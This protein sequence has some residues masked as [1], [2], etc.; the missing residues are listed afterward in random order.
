Y[1]A[2]RLR[3]IRQKEAEEAK[4][5][6]AEAAS[7]EGTT[8]RKAS[9]VRVGTSP[10]QATRL[11]RAFDVFP[12][13]DSLVTFWTRLQVDLTRESVR[14]TCHLPHGLSRDVRVLAFC[15]DDQ[16][17]EMLAA[18]ADF[19][20]ITEPLRRINQG[21]LGF[22][23]CLATPSIMPRVLSV[24]KILGPRKLIPNP[25]SG[26]VVTNLQAAI[27]EA[28]GGTLLEYRAEGEGEVKA[29][30]ADTNFSDAKI[31]ENLKFLV[32]TLLRAR[33]R[34]STAGEQ[35]DAMR[36]PPGTPLIKGKGPN[37]SESKDLYFQEAYLRLGTRGPPI[38]MDPES[39]MPSSVGAPEP[40]G[41]K[42]GKK[43]ALDPEAAARQAAAENEE[44]K[45]MEMIREAKRLRENCEREENHFHQ[46][47]ME[48]E[49]INYFWIV[50]KKTLTE[51]QA[52]LR[53]KQRELQ[54]LEERQ[55]IE[56]KMFQQR[57]KHLRY[58]Q[59][60]EVVEL[61]TDAELSLK[62]QEDHHRITEAEIKK[63]QRA[64]KMEKKESEVAQ[65]DFTRMLKLEQDGFDRKARDMQQKYELR[66]KTIREEMEKQRRKQIQ[67]IEESKNAQIEQVMKK[68]NLDFT[69]IKVYYQEITVSNFDSI[70]RLKEDYA[71]IKKDEND[72][73]KKM[74]D[75]EQRSK[76]LKEP[77]KKANQ[78]VE[79]LERE[80][81]A[82][83]EDKKRLT[84]VK[85]Q[86][87]QSETLLKRMEFQ[88]EVLQQQLSQVTSEREDLYTK[89]QQAI[90]DVQQR[91]GLKNLILEKKI[92][93]VEEALETTEAQI[94]ELLASAN[95]RE[96]AATIKKRVSSSTRKIGV[97]PTTSA[98]ITQKLDQV[99]AYKDDIV[100]QLEDA[101]QGALEATLQS[102]V[103]VKT[104]ESKMAE[105]GVP[106]EDLFSRIGRD[107]IPHLAT[108]LCRI[109]DSRPNAKVPVAA[110]PWHLHRETGGDGRGALLPLMASKG[111]NGPTRPHVAVPRAVLLT[112]EDLENFHN[113]ALSRDAVF[114]VHAV[115]HMHTLTCM[116]LGTA[117]Y[118][119]CG[120]AFLLASMFLPEST[121]IEIFTDYW[122]QSS[123]LDRL[124]FIGKLRGIATNSR[125]RLLLWKA[126]GE[127]QFA[128]A[129]YARSQPHGTE[130]ISVKDSI[131]QFSLSLPSMSLHVAHSSILPLATRRWLAAKHDN[132]DLTASTGQA[133]PRPYPGREKV[134]YTEEPKARPHRSLQRCNRDN[135]PNR[136]LLL[137]FLRIII[138]IIVVIIIIST[139][140]I[141]IIILVV[142]VIMIIM[143]VISLHHSLPPSTVSCIAIVGSISFVVL[144]SLG[145]IVN[146]EPNVTVEVDGA[147]R[148]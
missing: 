21:W 75:L 1:R 103:S 33:P 18:G 97:D 81:V 140:A 62:L 136:V 111:R 133:R 128:G 50:E 24:A 145:F 95:A 8:V 91:S 76:Q 71:S 65:Q 120:Q 36:K 9:E 139:F 85:E 117:V 11:M 4:V 14:G 16:V 102:E 68:N 61:K 63:D 84:S 47:L 12:E 110:L 80:Q 38:R 10:F 108:G 55:Q 72:D 2:N 124:K 67:K 147:Q 70:K 17:E 144:A 69:E 135:H 115:R 113:N 27:K 51:K 130:A 6:A 57:L 142:A 104:Y 28:K 109:A 7:S 44:K 39:L 40:M 122:Q 125:F 123:L 20:G 59:Q 56:L 100:S 121:K 78:D 34:S 19:A 88:H 32:Q 87:K 90:Y 52:D 43:K 35:T 86:I 93:T 26:S 101:V 99:I 5:A 46:F 48:R 53:N 131:V 141:V 30:I 37:P 116:F 138:I 73:A 106:P 54:D 105:Y 74:Y 132:R 92:D 82:Y 45:R 41:K 13:E 137:L 3:E 112:K 127:L 15:P 49:K 148:S 119:L 126:V 58:H 64:L 143:S 60:D 94:T 79:R 98:G 66:M 114:F 146:L 118:S 77:M 96:C 25:K 31:L 23:R 129:C 22:D 107:M 83:E 29:T 42:G 134:C 89:F